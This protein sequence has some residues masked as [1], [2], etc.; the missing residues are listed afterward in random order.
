MKKVTTMTSA[1]VLIMIW[2]LSL[3]TLS[4]FSPMTKAQE[5]C[6]AIT[7]HQNPIPLP[8]PTARHASVVHNGRIY[9][10]G[11]YDG[12]NQ[13]DNV[14]FGQ[15]RANGEIDAWNQT[16]PLPERRAGAA[17]VVWNNFVYVIAGAGP[18][19]EGRSEQNTIFY[20]QIMSDGSIGNWT[21]DQY[22][23]PERLVSHTAVVWNE[24]IYVLGGWNGYSPQNEI[25]Y[26]E[27]NP[28]NGSLA[29][30]W[31]QNPRNLPF[32]WEST[33]A[34]VHDG[35]I[36]MIGGWYGA[37]GPAHG[38]VMNAS[39]EADGT[40]GIWDD[41]PPDLPEARELIRAGVL[42]GDCIYVVGGRSGSGTTVFAEK[43]VYT[44]KF[45]IAHWTEVQSIP[46]GR[47]HH[48]VVAFNGRIYVIGGGDIVDTEYIIKDTIY[49]SS[50]TQSII[51]T[52]DTGFSCTT[53]LGSG[54]AADSKI[55]LSWDATMIPTVPNA[56][57]TDA[58]GSFTAIISVPTQN[59]PGT[60]TVNAT[61]ES[62][63]WTTATF[64]VVDMTG[65]QGPQ[66]D[67]GDKGDTG[68]Q[69]PQGDKGDKGDTGD[70]G[71]S[72][73]VSGELQFLVNGL[74]IAASVIAMGLATI[75]LFRKK[76]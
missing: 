52:P 69:G 28:A 63:N 61:D 1:R 13:F 10:I 29:H 26:T 12:V 66:G 56:L 7:W 53:V 5:I 34:L 9:V 47:R 2:F 14:S 74:T 20:A 44:A 55:T 57:F 70:Q 36:L 54:F 58:N 32:Q 46:E 39:V 40:I 71:P 45:S 21:L 68:D 23:L 65:D 37:T 38:K 76:P 24:R 19:W 64:T 17:A 67:K 42:I 4:M 51:L 49:Y 15:I 73:V 41:T 75:A 16:T 60:H 11:G 27:I 25:Y 30:A 35:T 62:G 50:P 33:T 59:T 43:T 48:S 18:T 6:A 8:T 22:L 72:G 3:T 31:T